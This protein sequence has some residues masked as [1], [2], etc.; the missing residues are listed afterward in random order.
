ME[1]LNNS[2]NNAFTRL[3]D[4][5]DPGDEIHV[6]VLTRLE[7]LPGDEMKLAVQVLD[8][9]GKTRFFHSVG[10]TGSARVIGWNLYLLDKTQGIRR[11][12]RSALAKLDLVES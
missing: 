8:P 10:L 7:G 1:L 2:T 12:V 3:R 9:G 4:S 6:D 11:S 5:C